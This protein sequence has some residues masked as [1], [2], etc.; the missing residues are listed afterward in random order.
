MRTWIIALGI[1]SLCL[2]MACCYL[3]YS[4]FDQ[5]ITIDHAHQEQRYLREDRDVVRKLAVDLAKGTKRDKV[6]EMLAKYSQQHIVKQEDNDTIFVDG[7][8]VRFRGDELSDILFM[9]E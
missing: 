1:V 9:N 3:L 7:V 4:T 6:E 2:L 8:G 5:A